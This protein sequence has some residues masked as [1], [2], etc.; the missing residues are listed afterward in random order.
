MMMPP[1]PTNLGQ[2]PPKKT[3]HS[4]QIDYKI[5]LVL[6][7]LA[8]P[9]C[10]CSL[11][12]DP[13]TNV[14]GFVIQ[15]DQ[16]VA[17]ILGRGFLEYLPFILQIPTT[18]LRLF[19]PFLASFLCLA[20]CSLPCLLPLGILYGVFVQSRSTRASVISPAGGLPIPPPKP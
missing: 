3:R 2:P 11:I 18:L 20:L 15:L 13:V 10:V 16:I 19:P 1:P 8:I 9:C 17:T 12:I 7:A 6:L 5:P 14:M 4:L